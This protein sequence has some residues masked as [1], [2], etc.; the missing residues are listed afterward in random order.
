MKDIKLWQFI[1]S[2]LEKDGSIILMVVVE[3]ENSSPG[4]AGFKMAVSKNKEMIGSIGGGMMEHKLVD[5]AVENLKNGKKILSLKKLYH[6]GDMC[7][8]SSG[9][10]CSGAETIFTITL[11]KND[12]STIKQI[13]DTI[14]NNK[15]GAL[16][17]DP[18]GL[19]Y[20]EDDLKKKRIIFNY[21]NELNW[22][23]QE[24]IGQKDTIYIIGGGHVG[25][26]LSKVMSL[27]DFYVVLFDNRRDLQTMKLNTF[28]NEKILINYDE[29]DSRLVEGEHS[30]VAIV[31]HTHETDRYVLGKV[32]NRNFKYVG[33]MGSKAKAKNIISEMKQLGIADEKINSIHSPIGID[34]KSETPEEIAIS[35]A[36]E[37]IKIR[38]S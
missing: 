9:M 12:L 13:I 36:A 38:N 10:I 29:I 25:L 14:L 4:R 2:H 27:L 34:I 3:S 37:I 31:S 1:K 24:T 19:S 17:F 35:I 30:Y 33:L 22:N 5:E 21:E 16:R 23:Y 8:D 26:A 32:I 7:E 6:Q 28:A 11:Q 20:H 18:K 15:I